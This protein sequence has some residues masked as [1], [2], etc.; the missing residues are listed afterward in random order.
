M[1]I[2]MIWQHLRL[3]SRLLYECRPELQM[4]YVRRLSP[5]HAHAEVTIPL[6][7]SI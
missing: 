2:T 3:T 7:T 5:R 6:A 4:L 1:A